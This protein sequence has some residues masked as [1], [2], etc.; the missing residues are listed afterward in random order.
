MN[1]KLRRLSAELPDE[2]HGDVATLEDCFSELVDGHVWSAPLSVHGEEPQADRMQTSCRA[3]VSR[4]KLVR[5]LRCCVHVCRSV[6]AGREAEGNVG[7]WTVHTGAGGVDKMD[8]SLS[9]LQK[10]SRFKRSILSPSRRN[11][12]C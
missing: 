4:Q 11:F 1:I 3:V 6:H 10:I 12:T 9:H 2:E 7:F 5:S 8:G